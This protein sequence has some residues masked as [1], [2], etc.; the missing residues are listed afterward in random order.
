MY[1]GPLMPWYFTT[2]CF[3]F[4]F[5]PHWLIGESWS[6]CTPVRHLWGTSRLKPQIWLSVDPASRVVWAQK[7]LTKQPTAE[8]IQVY[9]QRLQFER[10]FPYVHQGFLLFQASR[11]K[12]LSDGIANQRVSTHYG[13]HFLK[14][15]SSHCGLIIKQLTTW[16]TAP[17]QWCM[18]G[19]QL[20]QESSLGAASLRSILIEYSSNV[21]NAYT[22]TMS[23]VLF[24]LTIKQR[25]NL[26]LQYSIDYNVC[27]GYLAVFY[28]KRIVLSCQELFQ[29][30]IYLER[31]V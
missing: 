20:Q 19:L 27:F 1:F 22:F 15:K 11:F 5:F 12:T 26:L 3:Y 8:K 21:I 4:F 10:T 6:V 28:H 7:H 23:G 9:Y 31:Y 18:F 29:L 13:I 17:F 25:L 16:T 30:W 14:H 24:S 2:I